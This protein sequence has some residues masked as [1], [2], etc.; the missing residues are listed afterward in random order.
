MDEAVVDLGGEIE[1]GLD[2]ECKEERTRLGTW[3]L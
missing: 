2:D 1:R 3:K